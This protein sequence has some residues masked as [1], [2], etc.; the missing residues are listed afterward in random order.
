MSDG[1]ATRGGS[2]A[3][4][5]VERTMASADV[6]RFVDQAVAGR[7]AAPELIRSDNGP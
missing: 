3:A 2:P 1:M 7:G 4:L 5:E 6:I